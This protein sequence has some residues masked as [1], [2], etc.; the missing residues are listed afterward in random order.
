MSAIDEIRERL[1]AYP[2]AKVELG[3]DEVCVLP[4]D[5]TGFSVSISRTEA[6]YVVSFEGWHEHFSNP[7]EAKD[8]FAFGLIG[9]CRLEVGYRGTTPVSWTL[10]IRKDERWE[11]DSKVGLL[12]TP[13]WRSWSSAAKSNAGRDDIDSPM[14]GF[15]GGHFQA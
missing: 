12:I 6:N 2:R 1:A 10:Q 8:C 14:N 3:A 5:A 15:P 4:A 13:F 9:P 11:T 7:A